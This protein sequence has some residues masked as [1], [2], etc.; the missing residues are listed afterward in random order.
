MIFAYFPAEIFWGHFY[1]FVQILFQVFVLRSVVEATRVDLGKVSADLVTVHGH[2]FL[3]TE[4]RYFPAKD[5][6]DIAQFG[7][8]F[9]LEAPDLI[10]LAEVSDLVSVQH[11]LPVV[12]HKEEVHQMHLVNKEAFLLET[13]LAAE[14]EVAVYNLFQKDTIHIH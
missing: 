5:L 7:L 4:K 9:A 2:D 6:I 1:C 8:T 13:A 14:N 3:A 11:A 12:L 10:P